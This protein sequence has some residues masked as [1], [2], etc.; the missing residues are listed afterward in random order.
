[1][2][3]FWYFVLF[4]SFF[5]VLPVSFRYFVPFSFFFAPH[6]IFWFFCLLAFAENL[7]P[8]RQYVFMVTAES[9]KLVKPKIRNIIGLTK[10]K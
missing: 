4:L 5:L 6:F 3:C 7:K 10:K 9:R 8:I 2:E 1:M